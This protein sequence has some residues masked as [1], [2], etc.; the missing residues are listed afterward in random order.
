MNDLRNIVG[1]G[2]VK[3]DSHSQPS[4]NQ[5]GVFRSQHS[6][7]P[8][9]VHCRDGKC[10]N[11][12]RGTVQDVVSQ[13]VL[14]K[15][16]QEDIGTRTTQRGGLKSVS[17]DSEVLLRPWMGVG[18]GRH[19]PTRNVSTLSPQKALDVGKSYP[20]AVPSTGGDCLTLIVLNWYHARGQ[21][22]SQLRTCILGFSSVSWGN[23]RPTPLLVKS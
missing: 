18:S 12:S 7:G 13:S 6:A 10:C 21:R 4:M 22:P 3:S 20:K 17:A 8:Q 11:G 19:F 9:E 2:A 16:H 14:G 15:G 5:L 23:T 1:N